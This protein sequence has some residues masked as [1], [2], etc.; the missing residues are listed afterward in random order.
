MNVPKVMP[1]TSQMIC[2]L[3]S[4]TMFECDLVEFGLQ[5]DQFLKKPAPEG[6]TPNSQPPGCSSL[7]TGAR[8]TIILGRTR[9]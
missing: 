1:A 9:G 8:V 6:G 7:R 5:T 3:V 4:H 2:R